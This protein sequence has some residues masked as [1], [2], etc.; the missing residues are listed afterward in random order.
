VDP[1]AREAPSIVWCKYNGEQDMLAD[2]LPE[3]ASITGSTPENDRIKRI[4]SFQSGA[5]SILLSKPSILGFGL[6]LQVA[7]RQVFST[8]EDSYEDFHQAVK[9]SNRTG[10]KYPLDV[11]IPITELEM[12][13]LTTVLEKAKR[14]E[15]DEYEQEQLFKEVGHVDFN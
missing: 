12:P 2:E 6:N 7:R 14:V 9:R 1:F 15:Q 10:S 8:V 3:A 5:S 4:E 13:M 11:F